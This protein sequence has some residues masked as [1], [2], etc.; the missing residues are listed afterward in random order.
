MFQYMQ[1][2][3]F[4]GIIMSSCFYYKL[5]IVSMTGIL[6]VLFRFMLF[7]FFFLS[8]SFSLFLFLF[9][10]VRQL[11][12]MFLCDKMLDLSLVTF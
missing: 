12:E 6:K 10:I 1:T 5:F 4:I 8:L 7:L 2:C 9:L 3:L 11:L